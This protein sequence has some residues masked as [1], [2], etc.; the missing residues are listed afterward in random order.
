MPGDVTRILPYACATALITGM[1]LAIIW[2][3]I[4]LLL[5]WSMAGVTL[6]AAMGIA[7]V[8]YGRPQWLTAIPSPMWA[9]GTLLV[10]LVALGT[11]IQ[12]KL[13]PKPAASRSGKG[14]KRK[15]SDA[16]DDDDS[17]E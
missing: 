9:Q 4:S 8:E 3:R 5:G 12:W 16:D 11:I 2:P 7:A 17:D 6:L 15:K 13:G 10:L 14:S 1:G